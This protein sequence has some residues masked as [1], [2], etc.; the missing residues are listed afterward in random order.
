MKKKLILV[1]VTSLLMVA[2]MGAFLWRMNS[3]SDQMSEADQ[4]ILNEEKDLKEFQNGKL[5]NQV[6]EL[7]I[8]PLYISGDKKNVVT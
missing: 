8:I 4:K 2:G 1:L 7:D 3:L 6:N 5:I